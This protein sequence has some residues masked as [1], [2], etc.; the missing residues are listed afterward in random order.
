MSAIELVG[1]IPC[2]CPILEYPQEYTLIGLF[3]GTVS[4]E[5]IH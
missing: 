2:G 4:L 3:I 1:A 5:T